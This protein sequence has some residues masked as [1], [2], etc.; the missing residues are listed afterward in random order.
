MPIER[1]LEG[2]DLR[3]LLAMLA[4]LGF[5]LA[6]YVNQE[7]HFQAEDI[8]DPWWIRAIRPVAYLLLAWSFLWMLSYGNAR[9]WQP[10][11]PTILM[12][13]AID[14]ILFIRAVAIRARIR[15]TGIRPEAPAAAA[16][17]TALR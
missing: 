1:I 15:R 11:P 13:V 8:S 17:L 3:Y 5:F 12:I 7:T 9:S 2:L 4:I 10:W 16:K 6:V 14:M